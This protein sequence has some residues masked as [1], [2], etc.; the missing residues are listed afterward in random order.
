MQEKN[1]IEEQLK[2]ELKNYLKLNFNYHCQIVVPD[3]F[4]SIESWMSNVYSEIL[5]TKLTIDD[6]KEVENF[7]LNKRFNEVYKLVSLVCEKNSISW[8][9]NNAFDFEV[10]RLSR[11][12]NLEV[13][14]NILSKC[15]RETAADLYIIEKSKNN[16][17]FFKVNNIYKQKISLDFEKLIKK[18]YPVL[19]SRNL[20]NNWVFSEEELF[21]NTYI[22]ES[23][24]KWSKY[25]PK[26]ILNM[27]LD[28]TI[29]DFEE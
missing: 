27:W 23:D 15:A 22:I 8:L 3:E 4:D 24:Q 6:V 25:T 29:F 10:L 20:P 17:D 5:K 2:E 7:I 1:M 18:N 19:Y 11:N 13:I 14:H 21:I 28:K 12:F 9:K 16:K 26:E